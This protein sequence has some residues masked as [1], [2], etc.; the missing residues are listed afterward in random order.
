[1]QQREFA[2]AT[3]LRILTQGDDGETSGW[4][5]VITW[6]LKNE[7]SR[8]HLSQAD[9]WRCNVRGL[10]MAGGATAWNAVPRSWKSP[11]PSRKHSPTNTLILTRETNFNL[12]APQSCN[13]VNPHS[14]LQGTFL[15]QE[16]S[17]SLL[18]YRW[19]L[20]HLSQQGSPAKTLG[21][22]YVTATIGKLPF[23]GL[24]FFHF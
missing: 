5:Q 7:R 16:L 24:H 3:K 2:D 9:V 20:Y 12:L 1:M 13:R 8:V 17:P 22:C 11:G 19:A 14:L 10:N 21:L 4:V 18:G 15:T 23:S 6:D